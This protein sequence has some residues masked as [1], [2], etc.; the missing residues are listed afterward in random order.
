[1]KKDKK[2]MVGIVSVLILSLGFTSF[3]FAS[4]YSNFN[5]NFNGYGMM[6]GNVVGSGYG[7]GY[8]MMNGFGGHMGFG[9]MGNE[10]MSGMMGA[11]GNSNNYKYYNSEKMSEDEIK[12]TVEKYIETYDE[13]LEIGDM[14]VYKNSDYYVS[15]EEEDTGK[16]AME[17]LVNPYSGAIYPEYGPNMMWNEKY[18]M[19]GSRGFGMMGM[20]SW[21]NIN[22][23][24]SLEKLDRKKAV[25]IADEYVKEILDKDYSV[26]NEGHEFYGY[27]TFHVS[28]DDETVGMLS[29]NH[30]SGNVWYHTWHG[31]IEKI[32]SHH[33][34]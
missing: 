6:N 15:I 31:D 32:I 16:G 29:V 12:E 10:H 4:S 11:W 2:V 22:I 23:Y 25:S 8:R 27:Y 30:Y 5:G 19:H 14:F 21:N 33:D 20:G 34:E 24:D 1:M 3:A 18:G 9:H 17:L 13:N 26:E 7:N 28:K